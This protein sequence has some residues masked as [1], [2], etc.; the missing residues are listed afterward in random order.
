MFKTDKTEDAEKFQRDMQQAEHRPVV[1]GQHTCM[2]VIH[3]F[4]INT[5]VNTES[6]RSGQK[7]RSNTFGG[8]ECR[9]YNYSHN[10]KGST[11]EKNITNAWTVADLARLSRGFCSRLSRQLAKIFCKNCL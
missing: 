4:F 6:K 2:W 5:L 8:T 3:A 10:T 1:C 11:I 9:K 7:I